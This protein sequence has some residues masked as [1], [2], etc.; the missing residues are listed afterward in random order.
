VTVTPVHVP[1]PHYTF[2]YTVGIDPRKL[3]ILLA[4]I[5]AIFIII[6]RSGVRNEPQASSVQAN[7]AQQSYAGANPWISAFSR[8][9]IDETA[10]QDAQQ[11]NAG[12]RSFV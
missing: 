5:G 7:F 11:F 12:H 1:N 9:F 10:T 2:Y 3:L 6:R 8:A 4:K